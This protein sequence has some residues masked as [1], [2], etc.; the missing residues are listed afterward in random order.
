MGGTIKPKDS[1]GQSLFLKITIMRF[2]G[3]LLW[4]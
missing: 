2:E 3:G 4:V 1:F